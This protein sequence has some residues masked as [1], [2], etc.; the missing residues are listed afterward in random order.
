MYGD[1]LFETMRVSGGRIPLRDRHLARLSTGLV[2]LGIPLATET[3]LA[4]LEAFCDDVAS[5]IVKLVVT[6]GC[7]GRGYLPAA[8]AVPTV[9]LSL[10][11]LLVPDASIYAY[12][13]DLGVASLRLGRNPVLAGMKTLNRLE[14]VMI[15][16]ELDRHGFFEGLVQETGGGVVEGCSSNLFFLQ[17]NQVCTPSLEFAGVAGIMRGWILDRLAERGMPVA[18]GCFTLEEVLR[19]DGLFLCNSVAGI[20]PVR[21]VK[22]FSYQQV[23]LVYQ[24]SAEVQALFGD[25]R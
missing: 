11:P 13:A 5:G 25:P 14:Q 7:G 21:S 9:V 15:R 6:R 3:L 8:N 20:L 2:R 19:A 18:E 24:L 4:P 22:G 23:P 12:G 16:A 17:S 10:Y 1:G